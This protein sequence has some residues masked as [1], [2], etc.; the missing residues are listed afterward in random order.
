[1]CPPTDKGVLSQQYTGLPEWNTKHQGQLEEA[2]FVHNHREVG[3][4]SGSFSGVA[5]LYGFLRNLLF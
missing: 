3:K 4:S 2:M 1:M 5:V